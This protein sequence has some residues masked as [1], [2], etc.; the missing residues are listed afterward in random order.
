[1]KGENKGK[2]EIERTKWVESSVAS[3]RGGVPPGWH[4]PGGGGG[5][6]RMKREKLWLNLELKRSSLCRRRWLKRSS[7]FF[8]K[9]GGDTASVAAPG[10]TN[11]IVTRLTPLRKF[12]K[13]NHVTCRHRFWFVSCLIN[14]WLIDWLTA[15]LAG[16]HWLIDW[17]LAS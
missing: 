13:R 2:V 16:W 12:D 10:D 3:L 14:Q 7:V 6:H 1:M 4:P 8:R 15:W 9:K 5:W 11:P 17:F